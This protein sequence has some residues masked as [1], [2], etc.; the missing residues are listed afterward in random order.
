M[1][2]YLLT[3]SYT[4]AAWAAQIKDPQNRLEIVRPIFE[5]AGGSIES[6]FFGF[7]E[8]DLVLI[9]EFPDNVSAASVSILLAAGGGVTNVKTTPLMAIEDGI[10]ALKKAGGLSYTP[11]GG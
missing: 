4:D 8:S 7:G 2:H 9:V 3:G 10:E 11:P 1:A 6:A 5:A